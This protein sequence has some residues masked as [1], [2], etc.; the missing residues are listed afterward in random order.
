MIHL[1]SLGY[2]P[3]LR[4][5]HVRIPVLWESHTESIAGLARISMADAV[6][7]DSE[8]PRRIQKLVPLKELTG[9]LIAKELVARASRPMQNQNRI[10]HFATSAGDWLPQRP[11][12]ELDFA[13]FLATTK[14]EIA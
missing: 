14:L 10:F 9:E 8:I 1:K 11:V 6:R 12:V 4:L 5:E 7:H 2:Q 13:R 3:V